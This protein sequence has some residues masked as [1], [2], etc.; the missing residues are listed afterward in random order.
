MKIL[1]LTLKASVDL[2]GIECRYQNEIAAGIPVPFN[3]IE[4]VRRHTDL[5]LVW[6]NGMEYYGSIYQTHDK[7]VVYDTWD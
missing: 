7:P 4:E 1:V 2:R 6:C 3:T 5:G